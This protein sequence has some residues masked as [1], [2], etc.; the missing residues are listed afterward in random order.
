MS[1]SRLHKYALGGHDLGEQIE[2]HVSMLASNPF[3]VSTNRR[4]VTFQ[5]NHT[6]KLP[7]LLHTSAFIQ[8][9]ANFKGNATLQ[10]L[11]EVP[12]MTGQAFGTLSVDTY[13]KGN[14]DQR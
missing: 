2:R 1:F 3:L 8:E 14:I 5:A 9:L 10:G 7:V 11:G 12:D 13:A 4:K 6:N